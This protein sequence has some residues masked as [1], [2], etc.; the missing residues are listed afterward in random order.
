MVNQDFSKFNKI[1]QKHKSYSGDGTNDH[2]ERGMNDE[3]YNNR[4]ETDQAPGA[5]GRITSEINRDR[6]IQE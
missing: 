5:E 1:Q 6:E 2:Q 3:S 4:S